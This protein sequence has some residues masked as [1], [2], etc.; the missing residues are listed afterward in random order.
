MQGLPTVMP[1]EAGDYRL[2]PWQAL[3]AVMRKLLHT[4][5]GAWSHDQDFDGEKFYRNAA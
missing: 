4:I 3:I 5:W 1:D 2:A